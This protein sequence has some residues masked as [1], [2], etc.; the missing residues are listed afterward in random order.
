VSIQVNISYKKQAVQYTQ[1]LFMRTRVKGTY[2]TSCFH[3][4]RLRRFYHVHGWRPKS[5]A[6]KRDQNYEPWRKW[7]CSG[8]GGGQGQEASWEKGKNSEEQ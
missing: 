6:I 4:V 8:R 2:F 3:I 7:T 1:G 5:H